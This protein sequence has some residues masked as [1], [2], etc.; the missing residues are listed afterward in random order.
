MTDVNEIVTETKKEDIK[1]SLTNP[2]YKF[3][4]RYGEY[5]A[6]YLLSII[7]IT[8]ERFIILGRPIKIIIRI[9][10]IDICFVMNKNC[11]EDAPKTL[12][13]KSF[14]RNGTTV[15]KIPLNK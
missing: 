12:L 3:Y 9:Q 6:R 2:K 5:L 10:R 1:Y 14:D 4:V 8:V 15:I 11:K 13:T 7:Y